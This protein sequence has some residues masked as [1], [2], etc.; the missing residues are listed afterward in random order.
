MDREW[1]R[2]VI[3]HLT[4]GDVKY[5]IAMTEIG[6]VGLTGYFV[7]WMASLASFGATCSAVRAIEAGVLRRLESLSPR[8]TSAKVLFCDLDCCSIV[9]T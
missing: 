7:S 6:L 9:C 8:F 2:G 4:A 3:Q 5:S 1:A